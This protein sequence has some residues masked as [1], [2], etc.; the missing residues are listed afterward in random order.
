MNLGLIGGTLTTAAF[1]PQ[2]IKTVRTRETAS[3]SFQFALIQ[4]ISISL[5]LIYGILTHNVPLIV[6]N[7]PTVIFAGLIFVYKVIYG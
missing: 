5:W 7:V 1:L 6:F 3:I 2:V 4:L